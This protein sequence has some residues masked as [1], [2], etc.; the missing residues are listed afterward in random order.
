M[1]QWYSPFSIPCYNIATRC[2]VPC[3]TGP[4]IQCLRVLVWLPECQGR[5][6]VNVGVVTDDASQGHLPNLIELI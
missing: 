4:W 5:N 6:G 2:M 1:V 3:S